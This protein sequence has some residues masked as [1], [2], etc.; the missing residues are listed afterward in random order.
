MSDPFS[1]LELR[2]Q[3][4]AR[5]RRARRWR[6]LLVI[7]VMLLVGLGMVAV[8]FIA[9]P[10]VKRQLE[11]RLADTLHRAVTIRDLHL[12]PWVLSTTIDGLAINDRD[13]RLLFGCERLYAKVGFWSVF[14]G[15]WN[16]KE[17]SLTA[18]AARLEINRDGTLNISDLLTP[19]AEKTSA[20]EKS[21]SIRIGRLAVSQAR[22]TFADHSRAQDFSTELGPL[23]FSLEDFSTGPVAL[24]APY[25]FTASTEA[26]ESLHWRGTLSAAPLRSIGG[27]ALGS[28]ALKKYAPYFAGLVRGDVLAGTLDASGR[29][30]ID[31]GASPGV[32]RVGDGELHLHGLQL[33]P[34]GVATPAIDLPSADLTGLEVSL[35]P[36]KVSAAKLDLAGGNI[37]L[38]R[39]GDGTF[40]LAEIFA[41]PAGAQPSP[42]APDVALAVLEVHNLVLTLDDARAPRPAHN[43]MAEVDLLAQGI[44]LAPRAPPMP[45]ALAARLSPQGVLALKGSVSLAPRRADLAVEL[46]AFPLAGVTPC[47]EPLLNLRIAEGTASARGQLTVAVPAAAGPQVL[48]RGDA[49]IDRCAT[50]D[51]SGEGFV[52]FASLGCKQLDFT[53]APL[54]LAI[55]QVSLIEPSFHFTL[56]RNG[57]TNLDAVLRRVPAENS[58]TMISPPVLSL[59]PPSAASRPPPLV[60]RINIDRVVLT[61]GSFTFTDRSIEPNTSFA[62][63]DLAGLISGFSSDE[64]ARAKIDLRAQVDN[65]SPVSLAGRINLLS[66]DAFADLTAGCSDIDLQPASPY[67]VKYVGYSIGHGSLS[68]DVKIHLDQRHLDSQNV[69]TLNQFTLG[70]KT[71]RPSAIG[72]PVRFAVAM[73]KDASGK[74]VMNLPVQGSLDDPALPIGRVVLQAVTDLL[75]KATTAPLSLLGSMFGGA[76]QPLDHVDFAPG[77]SELGTIEMKKLDV[78]AR[79]LVARPGLNLEVAG[80]ADVDADT[81]WLQ[82][83]KLLQILRA[84]IWESRRNLDPG[85][86]PVDEIQISN[87]ERDRALVAFY[88]HTFAPGPAP[89]AVKTT[90]AHASE[91]PLQFLRNPVYFYNPS[92]GGASLGEG[93]KQAATPGSPAPNSPPVAMPTLQEMV[94]RLAARQ[95]VS[96]SEISQLA[97][98]RAQRVKD[99]LVE[100]GV[101]DE[102]ISFANIVVGSAP[103]V[104]LQLK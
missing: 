57:S 94:A 43:A 34:R 69:V 5:A 38:Q 52:S 42:V 53:S 92:T 85:L 35:A 84:R 104:T 8:A 31:L 24:G 64:R 65:S 22:F 76:N 87:D 86:P 16:F 18:P 70:E 66:S 81:P 100:Q 99:Y 48:F 30:E 4:G 102:R 61:N 29:Y 13:G 68:L 41:S 32:I 44:S 40:N 28:V 88:I 25:E 101:S 59:G 46:T 77:A 62:L 45:F 9:P 58:G 67:F 47:L 54:A 50:V 1:I 11:H 12:N 26:G 36:L 95:R 78:V 72:L 39:A 15:P 71:G 6:L 63:D 79:A 17:L 3:S 2:R 73:L 98:D 7:G 33:A 23:S 83:Q 93:A 21:W 103:R 49:E 20:A 60:S 19:P 14:Y 37:A 97:S 55:G 74:I 90:P 27:F 89:G 56:Y 75:A 82:R 96:D 80:D 51:G 10:F 91:G